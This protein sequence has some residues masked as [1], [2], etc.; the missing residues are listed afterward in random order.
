MGNGEKH[1][2]ESCEFRVATGFPMSR[3]NGPVFRPSIEWQ[4]EILH[5]EHVAKAVVEGHHRNI[6]EVGPTMRD[7]TLMVV[8]L[9]QVVA[10]WCHRSIGPEAKDSA[11]G[12]AA[13]MLVG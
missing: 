5:S 1:L 4:D 2:G 9:A 6:S 13:L 10:R 11:R 8:G 7:V 12:S 3:A